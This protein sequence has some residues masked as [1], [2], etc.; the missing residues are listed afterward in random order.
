MEPKMKEDEVTKVLAADEELK[1]MRE[2]LTEL[3]ED[4]AHHQKDEVARA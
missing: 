3:E 1:A 2:K 4:L